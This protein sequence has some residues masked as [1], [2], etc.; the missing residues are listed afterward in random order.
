MKLS[1]LILHRLSKQWATLYKEQYKQTGVHFE[2]EAYL[3]ILL[4]FLEIN[5]YEI[6]LKT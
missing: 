4:E 1:E 2:P 5:S 6:A 3:S